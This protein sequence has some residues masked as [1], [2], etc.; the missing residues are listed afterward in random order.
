MRLN[1][2][3]LTS[4]YTPAEG[5]LHCASTTRPGAGSGGGTP[6]HA[7]DDGQRHE[8]EQAA[9]DQRPESLSV[10]ELL[11]DVPGEVFVHFPMPRHWLGYSGLGVAVPIVLP[12]VANQ[13]APEC[14]ELAN[15]VGLLHPTA[16][17]ATLRMPGISPVV[18]SRYR[19][20]RFSS[21][22]GRVS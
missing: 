16:S 15:Q 8:I 22:S 4:I 13:H 7:R 3:C 18:R 6:A 9:D 20:R 1:L 19:S 12:T 21:N 17:S 11:Q 2:N 5:N 14:F 10:S